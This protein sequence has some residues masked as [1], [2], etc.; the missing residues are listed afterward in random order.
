MLEVA[1]QDL[2][3]AE[4]RLAA[5]QTAMAEAIDHRA[6]LLEQ[7]T[8]VRDRI[9]VLDGPE[10]GEVLAPAP[11]AVS[12]A[13]L[14]A[15]LEE[16]NRQVAVAGIDVDS[17]QTALAAA[18]DQLKA[19]VAVEAGLVEQEPPEAVSADQRDELVEDIEW[20]LLSRLAAQRSVGDAGSVPL[21]LDDTFRD[22]ELAEAVRLM[23][24]IERLSAAVQVIAVSDDLALSFWA[25]ALGTERA[26]VITLSG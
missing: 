1:E 12:L 8:A 22:L 15:Q 18:E 16:A 4:A 20:Y 24:S 5:I 2:V 6:R 14:E 13:E 26:A 9:G 25:E 7:E 3:V 21:L 19:S 11:D 17:A 23:E 10:G